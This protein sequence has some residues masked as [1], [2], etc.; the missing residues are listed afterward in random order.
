MNPLGSLQR[1]AIL[2][3]VL[4][5]AGG[6][7]GAWERHQ[8]RKDGEATG[9]AQVATL[10]AEYAT[11]TAKAE[12]DARAKEHASAQRMAQTAAY[13]QQELDDAKQ[14][15][16]R[17]IAGLR[18][19]DLRLRKRWTCPAG[20]GVSTT[21]AGTAGADAAAK[22]RDEDPQRAIRDAS[23]SRLVQYGAEADAQ[24]RALQAVIRAERGEP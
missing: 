14:D 11:A 8:G 13:Y 10:R 5:V 7:F 20:T 16:D 18:A 15:A 1:Y 22:L 9:A 24:I 3:L 21:V 19:G 6:T 17:T 23:A 4:I 12:A 2:A